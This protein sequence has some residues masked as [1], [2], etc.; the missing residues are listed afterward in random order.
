MVNLAENMP[1]CHPEPHGSKKML[2]LLLPM[3]NVYG[4]N[5]SDSTDRNLFVSIAHNS[6]TELPPMEMAI[7][8]ALSHNHQSLVRSVLDFSVLVNQLLSEGEG[9][10]AG[11]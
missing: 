7:S 10:L 11:K 9:G 4:G 3:W 2:L 6:A 1:D 8:L 5:C